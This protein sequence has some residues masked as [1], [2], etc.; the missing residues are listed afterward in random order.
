MYCKTRR[1]N[2]ARIAFTLV[3][4]MVVI[5]IIGLLAGAVAL[6]TRSYLISGK[7]AVAKLEISR[8]CQALDTFY[9]TSD[10]FPDQRRG[11]RDLGASNREISGWAIEQ[12]AGRSV[13]PPV[14]IRASG[15]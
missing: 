1:T 5:V 10:R 13:G 15:T 3:E 8:I 11:D 14:R 4:L 2:S 9:S 12:G 7:Q 6:G